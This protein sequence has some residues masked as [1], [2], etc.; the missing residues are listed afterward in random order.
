[1]KFLLLLIL[2]FPTSLV[3]SQE[4]FCDVR[5]MRVYD[6]DTITVDV[7]GDVVRVRL[8]SIDAPELDQPNGKESRDFLYHV[9]IGK[10]VCIY[11]D[12]IDIYRRWL[13]DVYADQLFVN[14]LMVE[15]GW[16]WVYWEFCRDT[17]FKEKERIARSKKLGLWVEDNPVPPW[18]WRKSAH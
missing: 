12:G 17:S 10:R 9:L 14:S 7:N 6:G 4:R 18:V 3:L 13:A 11:K 1:M 5:V 15:S 16:A 8:T 2:L